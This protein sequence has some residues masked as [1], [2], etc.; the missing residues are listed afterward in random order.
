MSHSI[1]VPGGTATFRDIPEL[2]ERHRRPL[3][4]L[5]L[6]I[7]D[8]LE[9][10]VMAATVTGP[11]GRSVTGQHAS[12]D[13]PQ[14][15]GEPV[16]LTVDQATALADMQDAVTWAFL[17]SWTVDRPFPQ[18]PDDLLDLPNDLYTALSEHASLLNSGPS[19]ESG[20][21]VSTETVADTSSPTGA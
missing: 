18:S 7:G 13:A 19:V 10:V 5:S 20:F 12:P 4:I 15:P 2:T 9:K 8:V 6:R 11:D 1:E 3:K 21:E 16:T 17:Q 14:L